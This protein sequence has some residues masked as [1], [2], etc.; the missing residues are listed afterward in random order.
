M[1]V[2]DPLHE[3]HGPRSRTRLSRRRQP[4]GAVSLRH[5]RDLRGRH[6]AD[7]H[8]GEI[9]ARRQGQ[10]RANPTPATRDGELG[11]QRQHP[12]IQ[13]GRPLQSRAQAAA[14][15]AAAQARDHK[16]IGAVEREGMTVVPLKLYFNERAAPRSR[17]RSPRAR[18]CTTSAR[19]RR[20][21]LAA[22]TRP[23]DAGE[24]MT[25]GGN[26]SSE[27]RSFR[28]SHSST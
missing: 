15:A 13:A 6:R 25:D 2:F 10:Y 3:C 22:R 14:Q 4:Q 28:G 19:P 20:S 23:A 7:R 24:G 11:S 17:S 27:C 16:L 9:A 5:R 1:A 18:S 8:R 26:A 12:R 21:A